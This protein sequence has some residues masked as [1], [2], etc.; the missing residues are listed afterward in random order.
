MA[1]QMSLNGH[2]TFIDGHPIDS[3]ATLWTLN[4]K[5]GGHYP[6]DT[7]L[8]LGQIEIHAIFLRQLV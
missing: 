4:G 6:H 8:T 3:S 2:N 7:L 1:P 5:N